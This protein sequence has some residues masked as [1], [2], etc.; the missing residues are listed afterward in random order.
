M[1]GIPALAKAFPKILPKAKTLDNGHD[2]LE[3]QQYLI[4]SPSLG[5]T[6]LPCVFCDEFFFLNNSQSRITN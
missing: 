6:C 4:S 3:T 1:I 2:D 5:E